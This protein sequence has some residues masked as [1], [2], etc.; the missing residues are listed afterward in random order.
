M[1]TTGHTTE[2]SVTVSVLGVATGKLPAGDNYKLA[3]TIRGIF[4][5]FQSQHFSC[6]YIWPQLIAYILIVEDL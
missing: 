6:V 1:T 3:A 2:W 4:V 5:I